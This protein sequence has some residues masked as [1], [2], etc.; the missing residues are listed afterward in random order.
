MDLYSMWTAWGS[1]TAIFK[2]TML[3][4][5]GGSVGIAHQGTPGF[6][7]NFS[8]GIGRGGC[9]LVCTGEVHVCGHASRGQRSTLAIVHMLLSPLF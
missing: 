4:M 3:L 7:S 2:K 9:V 5:E 1:D 6:M 8:W